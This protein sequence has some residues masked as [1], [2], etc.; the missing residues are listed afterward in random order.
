MKYLIPLI[1]LLTA[2]GKSH[3][4]Y[5]TSKTAKPNQDYF[6][7]EN[8]TLRVECS[9]WATR[10]RLSYNIYNKLNT[11]IFIDWKNSAFVL[12]GDFTPYW[13]DIT[14]S[15]LRAGTVSYYGVSSTSGS[16]QSVRA[17]RVSFIPPQAKINKKN[18][19]TLCKSDH[20]TNIEYNMAFRLYLAY[21]MNEETTNEKYI[22]CDF[23]V[24]E[25][26]PIKQMALNDYKSET[27]FY[28]LH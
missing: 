7:F 13:K 3:V 14:N 16:A 9:L 27:R 19:Q 28:T 10:G 18:Q 22:D 4:F 2:C 24:S 15:N 6:I 5:L 25:A 17:D 8:D 1:L 11:P 26:K 12:N 23:K 20:P 21:S